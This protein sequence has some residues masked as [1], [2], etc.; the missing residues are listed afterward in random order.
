MDYYASKNH[1]TL[2]IERVPGKGSVTRA[3]FPL[4]LAARE[5]P[6]ESGS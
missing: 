4:P 5:N 2:N 1:V 6:S 3:G